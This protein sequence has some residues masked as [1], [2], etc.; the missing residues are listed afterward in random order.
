MLSCI[1][2][3]P[4]PQDISSSFLPRG[5]KFRPGT[6]YTLILRKLAR[7]VS[8]HSRTQS[9]RMSRSLHPR[10]I[11]GCSISQT[12]QY[13]YQSRKQPR[14]QRGALC[15]DR[16]STYMAGIYTIHRFRRIWNVIQVPGIRELVGPQTASFRVSY[17]FTNTVILPLGTSI[18]FESVPLLRSLIP[19]SKYC[20]DLSHLSLPLDISRIPPLSDIPN[21]SHDQGLTTKTK[22]L[23]LVDPQVSV[24]RFSQTTDSDAIS[25]QLAEFL[26]ELFSRIQV[27]IWHADP[28]LPS[29]VE[30]IWEN[31]SKIINTRLGRPLAEKFP[32]FRCGTSSVTLVEVDS[33]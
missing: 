1:C 3:S 32:P 27:E 21:V 6:P 8:C 30:E 2:V 10:S 26:L 5:L 23:L 29:Q 13:L 25:H 14:K 18:H 28:W 11:E 9:Q 12:E 17:Y 7:P 15:S 31:T 20:P 22:L 16:F 4:E 19:F 24:C 33:D